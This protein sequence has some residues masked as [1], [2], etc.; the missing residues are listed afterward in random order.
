MRGNAQ[1]TLLTLLSR[2]TLGMGGVPVRFRYFVK[3]NPG[4]RVGDWI[5]EE[6]FEPGFPIKDIRF[7]TVINRR[8]RDSGA[9]PGKPQ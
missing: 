2:N 8:R 5:E 3:A 9:G 6:C 1:K 7:I 4:R